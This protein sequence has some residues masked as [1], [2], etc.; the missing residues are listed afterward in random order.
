M[1][2]RLCPKGNQHE[3]SLDLT[4][5]DATPPQPNRTVGALGRGVSVRKV[6]SVR[7]RR[8]CSETICPEAQCSRRDQPSSNQLGH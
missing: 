7:K 1:G 2:P 5:S 3:S 8:S 4:C 6:W